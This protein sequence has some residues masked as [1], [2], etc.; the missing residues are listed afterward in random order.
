MKKEFASLTEKWRLL[1]AADLVVFGF[2]KKELQ[3]LLIKRKYAPGAGAWA[4][5]GGFV[6]ADESLEDAARRELR[7]ETGLT[8]SG[9]LEQL[10]TFGAVDRDPR[11]RVISVAYLVLVN[12]AEKVKLKATDDALE[13][14]WFPIKDLPAFAFGAAHR[15]ILDYAEQRLKWKFEYSNVGLGLLPA[16][17]TLT[18]LQQLYEAVLAEA[19]DKRNFRKKILSLD[20]LLP[21]EEFKREL[22]RPAQL[23]RRRTKNLKIYQRIV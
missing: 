15:E 19:L 1:L 23:Y 2:V 7:E 17:F 20:L 14:R 8:E 6:R 12:E 22:G 3:V 4:L 9:Y 13:A 16:R 10:F 5:P 11:G 21:T 18:D